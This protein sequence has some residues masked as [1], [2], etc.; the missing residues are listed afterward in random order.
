MRVMK[1]CLVL[2]LSCSIAPIAAGQNLLQKINASGGVACEQFGHGLAISGTRIVVGAAAATDDP[3]MLC[4]SGPGAAYV[5]DRSG[6]QWLQTVRLVPPDGGSGDE[7]GNS[8]AVWGERIVVGSEHHDGAA[9]SNS[10]AAYVY[11][12]QG[13]SWVLVAKLEPSD[14]EQGQYFARSVAISGDWIVCGTRFDSTLGNQAGAAYTFQR[15]HTGSWIE[16]Q[17]LLASDGATKDMYGNSCSIDGGTLVVGSYQ[18][19]GPGGNK[20]GVAYVYELQDATWVETQ[21]L[22]PTPASSPAEFGRSVSIQGDRILVGARADGGPGAAYIF[23]R[24]SSWTQT[25]RLT[26]PHGQS[27]DQFGESVSIY[28]T[29]AVVGARLANN[30][31]GRAFLYEKQDT[32][33]VEAELVAPNPNVNGWHGYNVGVS[34]R[35]CAVGSPFD[36]DGAGSAAVYSVPSE[37]AVSYCTAGVSASGCQALMGSSGTASATATSG[38][39]LTAIDVEG[40]K[41]GLFFF[42]TNGRQA[43]PWGNGTSFQCVVPPVLRAPV[44]AGTGALGACDGSFSLDLNALWCPACPKPAKNP[45]AGALVQ[46]QLWYR[47]PASTSNQTTSMSDAREFSVAP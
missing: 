1:R 9:G 23:E 29:C 40:Q 10:G 28:G 16:T 4:A 32:G 20:Q 47:D 8:V 33:W 35:G 11:E 19:A 17:K 22:E 7:F 43:N 36:N 39:D 37:G 27:G 26:A 25:A 2:G 31:K 12:L 13:S 42:G 14:A 15:D 44:M 5:F 30:L 18:A 6:D 34:D 21:K 46:S 38:F 3:P 45:G 24:Q 41:D